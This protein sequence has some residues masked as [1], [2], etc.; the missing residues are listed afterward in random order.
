M[1]RSA[2]YCDVAREH[3]FEPL[4]VEGDLP[5]ELRGTLYRNGPGLFGSHGRRYHHMFE[6]QGA[7][8]AVRFAGGGASGAIRVVE[9]EGLRE[10][11]AAGRPLYSSAASRVRRIANALAQR[12][13]NASNVNV[14][15]WQERIFGVVDLSK[16]IEV[17]PST[18]ETVGETDLG[19]AIA[20]TFTAHLHAVAARD[21][22]YGFG[23]R[24]G[25]KTELDFYEL[26]ARGKVKRLGSLPIPATVIHDFA[27]TDRHLVFFLGP[28]RLSIPRA[29]LG[30]ARP[31][32]LVNWQAD[33]GGEVLIVPIDDVERAVRFPIEPFFVWHFA[34][35]FERGHEIIVDYVHHADVS[36]T[37]TMRDAASRAGGV[38]DMDGGELHRATID[39]RAKRLQLERAWGTKCEF[40]RVDSRGEG[41]ERRYVWLTANGGANPRSIARFDLHR[42]EAALWTP[43]RGQ[44]VTE[45]IF[46]PR[47]G[48]ERETDGWV[49]VLVYD[50]DAGS[51]HV[52]VLD[53]SA[54]ERGPLARV[55][56]DHAVPLTLHGTWVA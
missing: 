12:G 56:F 10:E 39:P 27:A 38:I 20:Q 19:G 13:N 31:E 16:P 7:I 43:P 2:L 48:G 32:R 23:I 36:A 15:A 35:A 54:P 4:K 34:N 1:S 11:R 47:P 44:H 17:S 33:L 5:S 18:L 14:L 25:R 52:A 40:P 6:G 8:S 29:L 46:A 21:A 45:P 24:Y 37:G 49:L 53:A 26:P 55:H 30:E 28:A 41:T 22:I 51:S 50:D 42:A 3:G 9:S